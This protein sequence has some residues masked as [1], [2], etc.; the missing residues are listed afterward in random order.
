MYVLWWSAHCQK[1]SAPAKRSTA[2]AAA[3]RTTNPLV[4]VLPR[5]EMQLGLQLA[6]RALAGQGDRRAAV[7]EA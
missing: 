5:R 3:S 6:E 2:L 4:L 7:H 1:H